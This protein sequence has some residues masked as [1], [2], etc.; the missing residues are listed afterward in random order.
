MVLFKFCSLL[1][2]EIHILGPDSTVINM[3]KERL[4][5]YPSSL[6][7]MQKDGV[8]NY[9]RTSEYEYYIVE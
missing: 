3:S 2:I 9:C 6:L 5:K 7:L 8:P 4:Q 1:S